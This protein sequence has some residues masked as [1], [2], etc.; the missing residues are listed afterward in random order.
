MNSPFRTVQ[1]YAE[2]RCGWHSTTKYGKKAQSAQNFDPIITIPLSYEIFFVQLSA[3]FAYFV[4]KLKCTVRR[5]KINY[6]E[7]ESNN[8]R[9]RTKILSSL[10]AAKVM[11]LLLFQAAGR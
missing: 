8:N 9:K 6:Y 10:Q 4:V 5:I 3:S 7:L 2:F 1:S 11:Y